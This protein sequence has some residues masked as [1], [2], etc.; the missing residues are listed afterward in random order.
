MQISLINSGDYSPS[1]PGNT[2]TQQRAPSPEASQVSSAAIVELPTKAV[3][4][5]G[6]AVSAGSLKQSVEKI[7]Q[8]VRMISSDLKFT[9]DEDTGID[10]VKVVD[11]ESKEVI[12][13]IPSK[14]VIAIAKALDQLQGLLVRDKA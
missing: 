11:V 1:V 13:Q 9:V 14:E 12:R 5:V 4:A 6:E 2:N 10:V 7:N 8:A 3:Q